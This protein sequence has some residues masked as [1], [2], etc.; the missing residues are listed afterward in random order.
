VSHLP[1]D[2][3]E[4][5]SLHSHTHKLTNLYCF[6][7]GCASL[8]YY[9]FKVLFLSRLIMASKC[10]SKQAGCTLPSIVSPIS[11]NCSLQVRAIMASKC[12]S[13]NSH[14]DGL[15]VHH[16]TRSITATSCISKLARL[17]PPSSH[18]HGLLV[19][20][21]KLP[22]SWPPGVPPSLL[23]LGLQQYRQWCS[24]R[25]SKEISKLARSS[26]QSVSLITHSHSVV[27]WWI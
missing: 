3:V 12:I 4:L 1:A 25:A 20:V 19:Y 2:H 11:L 17:W 24:V 26:P 6:S 18:D 14:D 23:N 10:I 27:K 15:L 22:Q 5:N 8:H 7:S 16:Q 13:P 9:H 21:F